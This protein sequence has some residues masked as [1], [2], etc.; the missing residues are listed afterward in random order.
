M[1]SAVI[2]ETYRNSEEVE[3]SLTTFDSF[4]VAT[5]FFIALGFHPRLFTFNYFVVVY[6][7]TSV[8]KL[9][10]ILGRKNLRFRYTLFYNLV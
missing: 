7:V 6:H 5:R 1:Q 2:E 3:P 9:I 4:R 10:G 8:I